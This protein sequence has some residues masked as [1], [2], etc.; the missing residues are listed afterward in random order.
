V[1]ILPPDFFEEF[2]ELI[3]LHKCAKDI[4]PALKGLYPIAIACD[5]S[6]NV[7]DVDQDGKEYRFRKN[8]P[9]PM[10]IP[11]GT[12]A[13]FQLEGYQGRIVS[14][15]TPDVFDLPEGYVTILHEF[16]HCYQY[17]TCEQALKMSLDIAQKAQE[18]GDSMW[19][20]EYPFPYRTGG[21][22]K[23]YQKFLTAVDEE[24]VSAIH[25]ARRELKEF[26]GLH[27]FEYMVWQEWKE[28]FARWVENQVKRTLGMREN[29]K[30][31]NQPFSRV[32]FY[33]G[34]E[35]FINFLVSID[36]S[37]VEDLGSLFQKVRSTY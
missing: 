17:E 7:F 25:L 28:G 6:F 37:I 21:F 18:A 33:A 31:L 16:V 32:S 20:I 27:D 12:R 3:N 29:K 14:V 34:G 19:E 5:K 4:H 24:S 26:L 23:P 11:V 30:G 8:L 9:L 35:A 13:A 2:N 10:P 22:T 1:L 15:V 36:A